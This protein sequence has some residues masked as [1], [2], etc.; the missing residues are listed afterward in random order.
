MSINTAYTGQRYNTPEHRTWAKTVAYMLPAIKLPA[1]P[2]QIY[3]KFGLSNKNADWDGPIKVCQDVICKKYG[4]DD[5]LIR[6]CT[7]VDIEIVEKGKEY[8]VFKIESLEQ[9]YDYSKKA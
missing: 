3:F 2:Y 1:P 7:G 4:F 9:P 5:R 6:R 8:F